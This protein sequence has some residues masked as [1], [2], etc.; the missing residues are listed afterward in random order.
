MRGDTTVQQVVQDLVD[1]GVNPQAEGAPV[2]VIGM[3]DLEQEVIQAVGKE[4]LYIRLVALSEE[5]HQRESLKNV[6]LLIAVQALQH[7][8]A[9]PLPQRPV[10]RHV[11]AIVSLLMLDYA[12]REVCPI[13]LE[14][15]T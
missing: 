4:V 12:V 7:S 1:Q 15:L 14:D 2:C 8:S 3:Q 13:A 5:V 11:S 6:L 9:D 10:I